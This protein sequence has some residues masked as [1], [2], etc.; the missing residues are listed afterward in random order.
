MRGRPDAR[1]EPYELDADAA[2]SLARGRRQGSGNLG[3]A[4]RLPEGEDENEWVA[5]HSQSQIRLVAEGGP[6][7]IST[8][9][10]GAVV[11]FFNHV[12]MLYGT[13]A[14]FCNKETVRRNARPL[15]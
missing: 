10:R 4:V 13:I 7:L 5:V 3:A 1:T 6:K 14:E 15:L 8:A 9:P 11:D 2:C 12:N